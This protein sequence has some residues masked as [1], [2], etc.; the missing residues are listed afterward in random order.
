MVKYSEANKALFS[1]KE[2]KGFLTMLIRDNGKGFDINELTE[3]NGIKNM[4]KRASEI[5][6]KLTIDSVPGEGTMILLNVA[7]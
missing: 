2:E 5:G 7:V 4:K 6:A 1:V 3:G